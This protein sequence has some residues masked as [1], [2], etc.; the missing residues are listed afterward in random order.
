[1][2][3]IVVAGDTSG[4]VTISAPAVAGTPTLTLPT[5]SGTIVATSGG[6]VPTSQLGSGSASSSTYLRGDQSWATISSNASYNIYY[7]LNSAVVG[8]NATGAQ[9]VFGVGVTLEA[10]TQ[11]EFEYYMVL[12]KT[13]GTTSHTIAP[14]FG[15]TATYNN[16]IWMGVASNWFTTYPITIGT[17]ISGG[18]NPVDFV[19]NTNVAAVATNGIT[20]ANNVFMVYSKGI[21]SVNAS[22]TFIPQYTLSAAP[23]GA[24]TTQIGSYIKLAKLGASGS[25]INIGSWS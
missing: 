4:S 6:Y 22:G 14:G 12:V 21:I 5:T 19:T 25:N 15:G 18:L 11:Y 8:S 2:S 13:A 9:S 16:F 10:S 23:G 3:S 24:Y 7:A 1:M 17:A 20:N